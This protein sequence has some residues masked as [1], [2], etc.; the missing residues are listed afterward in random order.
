MNAI[1]DSRS[2]RGGSPPHPSNACR[3]T[4]QSRPL[5]WDGVNSPSASDLALLTAPDGPTRSLPS[6]HRPARFRRS[7]AAQVRPKP[8]PPVPRHQRQLGSVGGALLHGDRAVF[9]HGWPASAL[10]EG[11]STRGGPMYSSGSTTV[12]RPRSTTAGRTPAAGRSAASRSRGFVRS[13]EGR[14]VDC[15]MRQFLRSRHRA[16]E[17][18]RVAG[19]AGQSRSVRPCRN[20]L[21]CEWG[22]A[23]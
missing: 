22:M 6:V 8:V 2:E 16:G 11:G 4:G 21:P 13:G 7:F 3:T 9:G 12:P 18:G 10:E 19:Q 15:G 1:A 17:E 20:V 23:S 14:G 5:S